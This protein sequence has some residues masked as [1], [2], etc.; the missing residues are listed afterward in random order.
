MGTLNKCYDKCFANARKGLIS[1]ATC[2]PPASDPATAACVTKGDGKTIA[3]IDKACLIDKADC[4]AP[5]SNDYPD[6]ATWTNQVDVAITGNVPS[7]YCE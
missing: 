3:A 1:V 4:T 7:T 2:A 6:G 5:D